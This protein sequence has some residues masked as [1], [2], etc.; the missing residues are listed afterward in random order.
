MASF[1]LLATGGDMTSSPAEQTKIMEEWGAWF[2]QLGDA[3]VDLG[4]PLNP[5]VMTVGR[6]GD[7]SEGAV[8]VAANGYTVIK[9]D[10]LAA[11]VELAKTCPGLKYG[12]KLTVYE[13]SS[14]M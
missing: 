11:A 7:V 6:D 3:V 13:K 10:S 9:A 1:L 4:S 5:T 12:T 2:A 14:M 8:G